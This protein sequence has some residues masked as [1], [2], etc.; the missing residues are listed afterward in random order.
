MLLTGFRVKYNDFE[1]LSR[2]SWECVICYAFALKKQ[3]NTGKPQA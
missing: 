2:E 1:R 3:V